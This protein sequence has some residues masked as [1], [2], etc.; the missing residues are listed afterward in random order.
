MRCRESL[1]P[2][3]SV[4]SHHPSSHTD[5]KFFPQLWTNRFLIR[6]HLRIRIV[7]VCQRKNGYKRSTI[8]IVVNQCSPI[9]FA[10]LHPTHETTGPIV[11]TSNAVLT[12]K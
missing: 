6:T 1:P 10:Q 9:F 5:D 11:A 4:N 2:E 12:F 8:L 3:I 7:L